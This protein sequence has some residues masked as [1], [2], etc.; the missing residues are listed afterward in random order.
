MQGIDSRITSEVGKLKGDIELMSTKIDSIADSIRDLPRAIPA[1]SAIWL[2]KKHTP[3]S[4]T[5]EHEMK[6]G[7]IFWV[8]ARRDLFEP[9][10][11]FKME[12]TGVAREPDTEEMCRGALLEEDG[13]RGGP[14]IQG[15]KDILWDEPDA[16]NEAMNL[17]E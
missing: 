5:P 2:C 16:W 8:V 15:S 7:A 3:K 10:G 17:G 9:W 1:P 11:P 4:L 13:R 12:I 14:V 6:V